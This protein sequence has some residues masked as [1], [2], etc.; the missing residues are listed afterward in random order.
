MSDTQPTAANLGAICL[1]DPAGTHQFVFGHVCWR[2]SAGSLP[3][4]RTSPPGTDPDGTG[5][6]AE[7]HQGCPWARTCETPRWSSLDWMD[8]ETEAPRGKAP[9][10][11][12]WCGCAMHEDGTVV[13]HQENAAGREAVWAS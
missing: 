2:F 7:R 9:P 10:Y 1:C 3:D 11:C 13:V 12:P 6:D 4:V 8:P 5:C